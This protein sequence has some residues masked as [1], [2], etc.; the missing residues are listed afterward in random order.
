MNQLAI[1]FDAPAPYQRH[2][3][4][5]KAAALSAEP[6]AGT[7][8]AVALA[9]LRGRGAAG[10]TDEEMQ[11]HI[12]LGANTQRPRLV[13]LVKG[14][15]VVDSGRTRRTRGGDEAVVWVAIEFAEGT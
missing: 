13:E 9:F 5:S 7:K 15:F 12:P 8:R 10:A 1:N 3:A 6:T 2:S 14:H 4:T 11:E